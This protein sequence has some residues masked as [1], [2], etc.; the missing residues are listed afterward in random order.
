MN[1][2]IL[3]KLSLVFSLGDSLVYVEGMWTEDA[4]LHRK[5]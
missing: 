4:Y 5:V 2:Q 1:F 3:E